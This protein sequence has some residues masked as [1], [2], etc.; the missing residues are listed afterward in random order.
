MNPCTI[1][2]LLFARPILELLLMSTSAILVEMFAMIS[3]A[4]SPT[5]ETPFR[6]F[7]LPKAH[8]LTMKTPGYLNFKSKVII[9]GSTFWF[10]IVRRA[11][12][13]L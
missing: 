7:T 9:E 2:A 8:L 6:I 4:I 3:L 5:A 12:L 11:V 1:F 13:N 10:R